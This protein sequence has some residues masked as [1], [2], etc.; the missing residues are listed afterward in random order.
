[1]DFGVTAKAAYDGTI[2]DNSDKD[3][4]YLVEIKVPRKAVEI[5]GGRLLLNFAL[6]E[7]YQSYRYDSAYFYA[8]RSLELAKALQN[9]Y[10][11]VKS[12]RNKIQNTVFILCVRICHRVNIAV[13]FG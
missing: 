2:G 12:P 1:M 8:N 10:G 7:E 9:N 13:G 6:F 11:I 4:G 5:T 3:N